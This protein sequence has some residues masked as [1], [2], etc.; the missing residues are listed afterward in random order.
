MAIQSAVVSRTN[1]KT[2]EKRTNL[3][4]ILALVIGI[5]LLIILASLLTLVPVQPNV[6]LDTTNQV[7][8]GTGVINFVP[9]QDTLCIPGPNEVAM[10]MGNGA[11]TADGQTVAANCAN[12]AGGQ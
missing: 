9:A 12:I 8:T 5:S 6:A 7:T 2:N 4:A 11:K 3:G 1:T 10:T